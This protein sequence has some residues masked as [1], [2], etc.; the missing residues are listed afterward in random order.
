METYEAQTMRLL[1]NLEDLFKEVKT[2]TV[3]NANK[4]PTYRK[5]G[6]CSSTIDKTEE[7]NEQ[8]GEQS[9]EEDEGLN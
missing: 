4:I 2:D 1:A 5:C 6:G 7:K 8:S 9:E 3:K